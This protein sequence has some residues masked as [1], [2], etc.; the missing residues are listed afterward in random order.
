MRSKLTC[1]LLGSSLLAQ[2]Q[3]STHEPR[4]P[5]PPVVGVTKYPE[6]QVLKALAPAPLDRAAPGVQQN[7][8]LPTKVDAASVFGHGDYLLFDQPTAD[9]PL[10]VVTPQWK[11]SFAAAGWSFVPFFGS[12]APRNYPVEFG[13]A[14]ASCGGELLPTR[15]AIPARQNQHLEYDRGAFAECFDLGSAGV[16]QSFR[17][18]R[19]PNRSELVL[20]IETHSELRGAGE[21]MGIAFRNELGSVSYGAAVAIDANGDRVAAP[22]TFMNGTITI[23]V[24]ASFLATA[25]LPLIIDPLVASRT[26]VSGTPHVGNSDVS[27]DEATHSHAVC[28]QLD[29]SATDSDCYVVRADLGMTT[30]NVVLIDGTA[31]SWAAPRIANNQSSSQFLVV[32]EV[33]NGHQAPFW[34]GGRLVSGAGSLSAPFDIERNGVAGHQPGSNF[35]PDVGGDPYTTPSYFT[36]V[37]EHEFSVLDHDIYMKQVTVNGTLRSAAPT[38]I[39]TSG[40]YQSNPT[41]SKSDGPGVSSLQRWAIVFQQTYA[42]L[43]EDLFGAL[44]TW[45]GQLVDPGNGYV[46]SIDGSAANTVFPRVSSPTDGNDRKFLVVSECGLANGSVRIHA[47]DSGLG[48]L[49]ANDLV[50][51]E[52]DAPR[53]GWMKRSPSVDC[54]GV[55]F[56]VAYMEALNNSNDWDVRCSLVSYDP[57]RFLTATAVGHALAGTGLPELFPEVASHYSSNGV[58]SDRVAASMQGGTPGAHFIVGATYSARALVGGMSLRLTG[59]GS[60]AITWTGLPEIGQRLDFTLHNNHPLTGYVFGLPANNPVGICA[61]CTAGVQ[62]SSL[63]GAQ[64]AFDIPPDPN[65]VG[66]TVSTQGFTFGGGPCLGQISLSD[67]VDITI[68]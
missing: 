2:G 14:Q 38:P 66:V 17:F 45:D 31:T 68:L 9:G 49:W 50:S 7:G 53:S 47:V 48:G 26:L 36:V 43:D 56:T 1:L 52:N 11:A 55:R 39:A 61:G 5:R 4:V 13:A 67:T 42:L 58:R 10:W 12:E 34:I 28:Y 29:F 33:S 46:V 19:L 22:T 32:C 23:R 44:V 15:T 37:W 30:L 16:E 21:G 20:S 35:R 59:C 27:W 64:L 24:P 54:D 8:P 62:G 25:S 60:L 3:P 40:A 18:D 63:L 6:P 51:L 57:L 65:F 41:I